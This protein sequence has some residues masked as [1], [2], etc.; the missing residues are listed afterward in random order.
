MSEG[1]KGDMRKVV[2]VIN[3]DFLYSGCCD[4][5]AAR[6]KRLGLTAYGYSLQSAAYKVKRMLVSMVNAHRAR[7]DVE[8]WLNSSGV[9]WSWLDEYKG[10]VR[11]EDSDAAVKRGRQSADWV[12][13]FPVGVAV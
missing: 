3:P 5:Y 9:E 4:A 13:L 12:K 8:E 11:V 10:A 1:I 6:I 2:V 7:G